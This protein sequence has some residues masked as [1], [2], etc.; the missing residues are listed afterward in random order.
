VSSANRFECFPKIATAVK[1]AHDIE[2]LLPITIGQRIAAGMHKG[3]I[4]LAIDRDTRPR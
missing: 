1:E 3:A 2:G 4:R